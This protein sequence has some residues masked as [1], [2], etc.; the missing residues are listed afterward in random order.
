MKKMLLILLVLIMSALSCSPISAYTEYDDEYYEYFEDRDYGV[1]L[2]KLFILKD[3]EPVEV[4]TVMQNTTQKLTVRPYP[5]RA[6]PNVRWYSTDETVATVDDNGVVTGVGIGVCKVYAV[7]KI[8]STKKDVV[9]VNVTRYV[10]NPDR[11]SFVPEEGSKFETGNMVKLVPTFY[12]EDTTEKA[13]RWFVY[14]NGAT[15]D[16]NGVLTLK[17]KGKLKVTAMSFDW[18]VSYSM[19]IDIK[20]AENHFA[21]IGRAY[22]ARGTKPV[23]IEFDTKVSV[24]SAYSNIFATGDASG[25]G[26]LTDIE[27][28]VNGNTVTVKP[29]NVWKTGENYIFIKDGIKD[30]YGNTLG[31]NFKYMLHVRKG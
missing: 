12:P 24:D 19:E 9:T 21:E 4:I 17:E 14:G 20:Y 31:E 10:R 8:S 13:L 26:E 2:Y 30:K 29:K 22:N 3:S 15:I 16:Q 27:I 11:I 23:I 6:N 7:S 18:K 5:E 1:G 25:N 28:T